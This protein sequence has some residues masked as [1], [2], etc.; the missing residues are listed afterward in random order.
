[1]DTTVVDQPAVLV[2]N[3]EEL[4]PNVTDYINSLRSAS[5]LSQSPVFKHHAGMHACTMEKDK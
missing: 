2:L 3:T 5:I 1:M 4:S